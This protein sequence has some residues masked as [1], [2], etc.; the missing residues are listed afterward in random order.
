[1]TRTAETIIKKL[2]ERAL[3]PGEA[4]AAIKQETGKDS[5]GCFPIYTPEEIVY[6][7]GFIPVGMW[8]GRTTIQKADAYLQGF[9]CSIM[10]ANMEFGLRGVYS[11]LK[12]IIIPGLCDTL[13]CMIENW[14][15][16]VPDPPMIAMIYPQTRWVKAAE[17]YLTEEYKRV[18]KELERATGVLITESAIE[19]AFEL[20]EEWRA[21]MREFVTVARD[22]P[23]TVD[24]ASR[25]LIIKAGYFM[26]KAE[27]LKDIRELTSRLRAGER[28]SMD[29]IRAVLTGLIAEPIEV[30]EIFKECGISVV[31]DDLAQ[32]SRQFRT[33]A[34]ET[35]DVWERMAGRI[36]DQRGCTFLC[37][38][39]KVRGRMLIDMAA[40]T[41]AD[42]V[43]VCMLKFCDPEE[44]DYPVYKAQLEAE[45]IPHLYLELDQL[46]T[47]FEQ[48]RTRTQ[49]FAEMM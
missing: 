37:E 10:Q 40:E 44:F 25:H 36:I 12:A 22:Y 11:G 32:E 46:M 30:L 48:I 14:K 31:A 8:G 38:E 39:K 18:R 3:S 9:C 15:N 45:G 20:Y 19:A 4:V 23:V 28:E 5:V 13:K 41:S 47:S 6:A 35:G 17:T 24:A 33:P 34:R 21:A 29:G 42:A 1:M 7:G 2:R 27:H 16:G 26:D 49:S 43:I